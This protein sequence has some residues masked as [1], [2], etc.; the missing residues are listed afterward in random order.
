MAAPI[1]SVSFWHRTATPTTARWAATLSAVAAHAQVAVRETG[2]DLVVVL[3]GD[4]A[5]LEAARTLPQAPLMMGINLGTVGFLATIRDQTQFEERFRHILAGAYE[6]IERLML[7]AEIR[8]GTNAIATTTCLNEISIHSLL[9]IVSIDAFT[10]ETR[11]Q[12][13]RGSGML[14]ATPTGSTGSNLSAHGPIVDPSMACLI[15]TELLDHAVPT[16]SIVVPPNRSIMLRITDF[17]ERKQFLLQ[18]STPADVVI[19]ADGVVVAAARPGDQVHIRAA[20]RKLPM[21]AL[22]PN[23][24]YTSLHDQFSIT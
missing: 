14:V 7:H 1:R 3:G 9:G 22:E 20:E 23:T 19:A 6:I 13:V 2:A 10:D 16:P 17:R 12:Q 8:R 18:D 11:I 24:F 4:G 15:L 21:V 5:I